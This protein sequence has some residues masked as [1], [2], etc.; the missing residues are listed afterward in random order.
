VAVFIADTDVLIDFL[1]GSGEAERIRI[2]IRTGRLS[3]TAITAFELWAGAGSQP[4]IAAVE[5]L[6]GALSILPLDPTSARRA[7][8]IHR[9]LARKGTAI[10]M[11]DALI[12]GLCLEHDAILLTRN[13]RHYERVP[14]IH[15]GY[16]FA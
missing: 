4:Q 5:T 12:A 8:Q 3:T 7:A 2:E 10:G 9:D 6:L 15:F 13:R 16:R 11:A 1:R 14:G